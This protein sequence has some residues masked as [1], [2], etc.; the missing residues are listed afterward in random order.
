MFKTMN[1]AD[2][3]VHHHKTLLYGHHGFGK[4]TQFK[5]YR[6][7]YGRGLIISGESGLSSVS[8][9]DIDFLPFSSWDGEHNPDTGVYSFVGIVRMLRTPEFKAMGYAWL[10]IDSLTEMSE[11]CLSHFQKFHEDKARAENKKADGF[12]SWGDYERAM[13]AYLKWVRDLDLHVLVTALAAEE[14]D[15]NGVS[16]YW[17]AVKMKKLAKHVCGLFDHVF[18]GIRKTVE[19][20]GEPRVARFLVTDEVKG[21]HGKTRDPKQRL[22]P[23]ERV[24]SVVELHTRMAMSEA[25]YAALTAT[26]EAVAA[27]AAQAQAALGG[28]TITAELEPGLAA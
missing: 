21:W 28:D 5:Y 6:E 24:A 9:S 4:T 12:A 8:D 26:R 3:T 14:D 22:R 2:V 27:A 13:V 25:D 23:I 1:T 19:V 11:R 18:C 17:P 16:N 10:G 20:N 7:T 15:D